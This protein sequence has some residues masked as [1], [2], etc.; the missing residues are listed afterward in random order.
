MTIPFYDFPSF[1]ILLRVALGIALIIEFEKK[2]LI[3]EQNEL[4]ERLEKIELD[5]KNYFYRIDLKIWNSR[6]KFFK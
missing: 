1:P 3:K 5:F 4:N 6:P 2:T